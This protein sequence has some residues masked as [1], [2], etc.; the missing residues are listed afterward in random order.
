MNISDRIQSVATWITFRSFQL[1]PTAV[2]SALGAG[3]AHTYALY[4]ELRGQLWIKRLKRNIAAITGEDDLKKIARRA[5]QQIRNSGRVTAEFPSIDAEH[6]RRIIKIHGAHHVD[7]ITGPDNTRPI[8]IVSAHMANWEIGGA[9]LVFR[10][11]PITSIYMPP[12]NPTVHRLAVESRHR[13]LA[14]APGSRLIDVSH[15]ATKKL[16][17]AA[18]NGENLQL[19]VDEE[20][21]GLVWCPPLGRTLPD[22]GNRMLAALLAL[23]YDYTILPVRIRRTRGFGFEM[24]IEAPMQITRTGSS[25]TDTKRLADEIA[26]MVELWVRAE[27]EQWYWM[28]DLNLDRPFPK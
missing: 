8:M 12:R 25:A 4:A 2:G 20:K 15:D 7:G 17:R 5:F 11:I 26:A 13:I 24:I 14:G 10:G 28:P 22:K 27:P 21:D 9:S 3:M 18:R 19:F 1:L 16:L 23:K 6:V